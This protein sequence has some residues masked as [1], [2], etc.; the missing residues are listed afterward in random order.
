MWPHRAGHKGAP[1]I[2]CM[3]IYNCLW[4]EHINTG[5]H[6]Q[7]NH[8]SFQNDTRIST[9]INWC[10]RACAHA[11]EKWQACNFLSAHWS[12]ICANRGEGAPVHTR[13][14][15]KHTQPTTCRWD[16]AGCLRWSDARHWRSSCC[17]GDMKAFNPEW[18]CRFDVAVPE[19]VR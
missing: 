1:T 19:A 13:Q 4:R 10:E 17:V 11:P 7:Y 9:C 18:P 15:W 6:T 12:S 5:V 8:E 3:C 14:T 16:G 2:L